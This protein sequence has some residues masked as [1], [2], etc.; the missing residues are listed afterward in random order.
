MFAS[1]WSL[2]ILCWPSQ[3]IFKRQRM[4]SS[5]SQQSLHSTPAPPPAKLSFNYF[6]GCGLDMSQVWCLPTGMLILVNYITWVTHMS[7]TASCTFFFKKKMFSI[8]VCFFKGDLFAWLETEKLQRVIWKH[9]CVLNWFSHT[10]LFATLWTIT[11]Q[12]PLAMGFP[13]KNNGLAIMKKS[14]NNKCWRGCGQKGIFLYCWW[15]CKL[16]QPLWRQYGD[17]LKN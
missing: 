6:L 9:V 12:A 10:W 11:C 8:L 17:S 3:W 13:S 7:N 16:I 2:L 14:T 4:F 1:D 15:E 5:P